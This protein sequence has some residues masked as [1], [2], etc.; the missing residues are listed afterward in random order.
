[1]LR[2][3]RH[4]FSSNELKN[5]GTSRLW[6]EQQCIISLASDSCC[7]TQF[8]GISSI[9]FADTTS[10]FEKKDGRISQ[11]FHLYKWNSPFPTA[12]LCRGSALW[13][14]TQW[15]IEGC[16]APS[17]PQ[18]LPFISSRIFSFHL[19]VSCLLSLFSITFSI[20][21]RGLLGPERTSLS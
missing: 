10:P 5:I 9:I 17:V 20:V 2:T 19:F 15:F 7:V 21:L 3:L 6:Q 18:P 14:F 8:E 12:T 4:L 11:K 1:M 16:G 13:C